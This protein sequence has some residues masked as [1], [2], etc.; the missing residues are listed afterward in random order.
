MNTRNNRHLINTA[1]AGL[2]ATAPLAASADNIVSPSGTE[3]C[4]G[5]AEAGKNDCATS[6][7]ACAGSAQTSNSP[8]DFK[9]VP[10]GTCEQLGGKLKPE[11]S[12]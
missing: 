5:V 3:P 2:L 9:F 4:Y 11:A 10:K 12:K 1:I 7:H 6:K 8:I